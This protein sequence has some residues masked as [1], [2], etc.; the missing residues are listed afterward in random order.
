MTMLMCF[1][2]HV[3]EVPHARLAG[4][5]ERQMRLGRER[6]R[7]KKKHRQVYDPWAAKHAAR[8]MA[9]LLTTNSFEARVCWPIDCS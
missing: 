6:E 1:G 8:Y 2:T 9:P 4:K 3:F 5:R 7:E